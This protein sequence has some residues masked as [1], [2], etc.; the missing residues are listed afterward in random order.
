MWLADPTA[1]CRW[2]WMNLVVG[3]VVSAAV[4]PLAWFSGS[5]VLLGRGGGWS[6][7]LRFGLWQVADCVDGGGEWLRPGPVAG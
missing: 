4:A 1:A 3:C 5:A 2:L 6:A 7:G